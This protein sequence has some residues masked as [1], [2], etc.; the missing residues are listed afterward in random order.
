[1]KQL[2]IKEVQKINEKLQNTDP[3]FF[4]ANPQ[5]LY[6]LSIWCAAQKSFTGEQMAIAKKDWQDAKKK[7]YE[8]F[9]ISNE[10]NKTRVE[11]YGVMAVKDYIAACCGDLEAKYEFVERTNNACG[12]MEDAARSV[13]SSLREEQK[14]YNY[15]GGT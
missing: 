11:K 7:A 15:G 3:A 4:A 12:Y 8:T 10:A 1:M 5:A 6:E 2:N 14:S 13:M 9:V